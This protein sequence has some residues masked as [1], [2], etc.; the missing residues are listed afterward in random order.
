MTKLRSFVKNYRDQLVFAA[1]MLF[2]AF[3]ILV[4][5]WIHQPDD[6]EAFY[7]WS[8]IWQQ[9]WD[10]IYVNCQSCNYPILGMFFSA[11]MTRMIGI[12]EQTQMV[13]G[14]RYYLAFVDLLTVLALYSLL[15]K[16]GNERPAF[17]AGII[18][19]LPSSWMGASYW[20]QIDGVGQ[21]LILVVFV[22]VAHFNLQ[23]EVRDGQK[24]IY[25]IVLGVLLACLLMTKQLVLFSLI[26]LGLMAI[27]NITLVS[28]TW[29][30]RLFLSILFSISLALP[31]LAFD[32][33]LTLPPPY[34]S[35]L[36]YVL[37][38]GSSHGDVVASY[39]FNVW[40]LF[41]DNPFVPSSEPLT[42]S[43]FGLPLFTVVPFTAGMALFLFTLLL[44]AFAAAY[45]H[46]KTIFIG[47]RFF[48]K[49][50]LVFWL[51]H[52]GLVNLAFNL[53]LSGAHERYLFHFYPFVIAAL[54]SLPCTTKNLSPILAGAVFYGVFLFGYLTGLN[55][56]VGR[57][58]F[59]GMAVFHLVLLV[60]LSR[61][62]IRHLRDNP[63]PA[64]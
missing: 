19:L 18:G 47:N 64:G 39:G 12:T 61:V 5:P 51:L 24:R 54:L 29:G 32:F 42:I 58:M 52:L 26:S 4:Y 41:L 53:W 38:T 22:W 16:L 13:W 37:A 44:L 9:G 17:W 63:T 50:D 28:R 6:L 45:Y 23:S 3:A 20:G 2:P 62:F 34:V 25:V 27:V 30:E 33:T 36:H 10:A 31:I 11:G 57:L 43:I 46:R 8:L 35:H 56:W 21:L 40:S 1:G 15:K 55:E 48:G 60:Y 49:Q 7:R 59:N 14:F